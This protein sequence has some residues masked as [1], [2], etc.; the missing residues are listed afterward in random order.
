MLTPNICTFSICCFTKN[1]FTHRHTDTHTHKHIQTQC[2]LKKELWWIIGFYHNQCSLLIWSL[3]FILFKL[4]F[5]ILLCKCILNNIFL[6]YI[7]TDLEFSV[8]QY[9][10]VYSVLINIPLILKHILQKIVAKQ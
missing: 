7:D 2:Q 3:I 4:L 5:S 10:K 9:Q 8:M 1:K 6:L